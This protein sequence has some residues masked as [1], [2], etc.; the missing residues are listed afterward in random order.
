M[1]SSTRLILLAVL[2]M[3]ASMMT[4][5]PA[6]ILVIPCLAQE[7]E[8]GFQPMVGMYIHQHWPYRNPYAART[9]TLADWQGYLDGLRKLGFNTVLVWPM[10]ETMPDP[11]TPSDEANLEKISRVIDLAHGHFGMRIY[12]VVC[13]NVA[14]NDALAAQYKFEERPYFY[15]DIRV[16]PGDPEALVDM[17]AWR[18]TLLRPLAHA[19]GVMII[20]SDPGGYPGSGNVEFVYLLGAYRRM[21]DRLRPGIE[22]YYWIH[23]GWP[24]YGRFYETAFFERGTDE[25]FSEALIMMRD[26]DPEPWGLANGLRHAEELD[27]SDRVVNF[28][29]GA[30]EAEPS[31]PMTNFGGDRAMEAGARAA[32]R[33][34]V[35][36]SQTH[37]VQLPNTFAFSRGALGLPV[38]ES[39]YVRFANDLLP[40][41]GE[42]IVA[43]WQA[44]SQTDPERMRRVAE[45]LAPLA[46]GDL[47][48]G[49]LRGL[50]FGDAMRFVNDLLMQ[51]ELKATMEDFRAALRSSRSQQEITSS[52]RDFLQAAEQW[53]QQHGY[54]NHWRWERMKETLLELNSPSLTHVLEQSRHRGLGR[55]GF[56]R[57][58]HGYHRR[59]TYTPRL[60]GAMKETLRKMEAQ[61]GRE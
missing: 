61:S 40:G 16:D 48:T 35:G 44:L 14:A 58:Q 38:A 1:H 31:F 39:D 3:I 55:T 59:E 21:L 11:L 46:S 50:L 10:L 27:L 34:A 54:K 42:R 15:T 51:L 29:Y 32:P 4:S 37:C 12:V 41:N 25:E 56:E 28:N 33:G 23:A 57:V 30:I 22:L 2:S 5:M 26:L 7:E 19:D 52:F 6:S 20:D 60:I 53:Q 17:I 36:N 47:A 13:P 43:A 45:Q 9:W 49:P 24:A 8:E 18:E